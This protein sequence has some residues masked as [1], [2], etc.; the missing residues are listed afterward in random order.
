[1]ETATEAVLE[2]GTA[3]S[4]TEL[5]FESNEAKSQAIETFDEK[6]GD[7]KQL[8]RIMKAPVKVREKPVET[9]PASPSLEKATTTPPP[10]N[11]KPEEKLSAK[12]KQQQQQA[13]PPKTVASSWDGM[14]KE[15]GFKNAGEFF[16]SWDE[17]QAL[18]E[19]QQNFI[20]EKLEKTDDR[21][22][23][24]IRQNKEYQEKIAAMNQYVPSTIPQVQQ[25]QQQQVTQTKDNIA[26]IKNML[27]SNAQ[28]LKQLS[29]MRLKD[30]TV[31]MDNDYLKT[32]DSLE[33]ERVSLNNLML[34]EVIN[35]KGML[36]NANQKASETGNQL[37]TFLKTAEERDK[38]EKLQKMTEGEL[39]EINTFAGSYPEFHFSEGQNSRTVEDSYVKWANLVASAYYGQ[40]VDMRNP[41]HR[42]AIHG[43]MKSLAADDPEVK[44]ACDLAG[45]PKIPTADVQK[46]LDICELLDKRDGY[47]YNTQ[48]GKVEQQKR[49]MPDGKGGFT[50]QPVIFKSL[51]DAY[52]HK[53]A[54]DGT[55]AKRIKESYSKGSADLAK[56][57]EKRETAPVELDNATGSSSQDAGTGMTLEQA[58]EITE[59]I[60]PQ[61]AVQK[62]YQGDSVDYDKLMQAFA[63][64]EQAKQQYNKK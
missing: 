21:Y 45:V 31:Q 49:L 13:T 17:K 63:F 28:K 25:T 48:T 32:L 43:V 58:I 36:D 30:P 6:A 29:D 3:T 38:Q 19:R 42:N 12:P 59:Q 40:P 37:Q 39:D 34:E 27:Q 61:V 33:N 50:E 53:L 23:D 51:K 9:K 24:L 2:N 26:E 1:M 11:Q 35:L 41:A 20:K 64:I 10:A 52:E 57:I 7:V 62:R 4:P 47:F 14:A 54:T 16:K 56:A 18:V 55:Y 8:E 60:D 5:S 44:K 22:A 46:Y 15:R